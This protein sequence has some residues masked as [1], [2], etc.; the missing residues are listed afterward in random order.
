VE[1]EPAKRVF[2]SPLTI[3]TLILV[4]VWVAAFFIPSGQ[5]RLD[6]AGSPI[7]G[8]YERVDS[9]LNFGERVKDLV[10]APVNGLYG[11][12]NTETGFVSPFG[13][14]PCSVWP[15]CSCSSWRSAGS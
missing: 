13:T 2:P 8:S 9:P 3:L 11:L 15:R 7:A 1:A 4:L 5:F 14:G 6:D 12:Q 10:L